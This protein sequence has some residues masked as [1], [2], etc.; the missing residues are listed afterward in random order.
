MPRAYWPL[1]N[2]CPFIQVE[3]SR[4][5]GT[6]QGLVRRLV[7]DTGAGTRQSV[8][9]LV[10]AENEC[11]QCG[12]ILMGPVQLGGAYAGWFPVYLVWV[13]VALLNFDEP[14]PVVA[15]SH[16]PAGFDG[17]AGFK[18]LNRFHYGN[19]GDP[20]SFGLDLLPAP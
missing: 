20:G 6:G 17:I 15:V 2:D 18:F 14:V 10:L 12:G 3:L 7:A 1:Q 13:R 19:F 11:L 4:F 9:Q 5:S 8:F 16:V